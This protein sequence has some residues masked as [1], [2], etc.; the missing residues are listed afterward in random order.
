MKKLKA[1]FLMTLLVL[2]AVTAYFVFLGKNVYVR[3]SNNSMNRKNVFLKAWVDDKIIF[4]DS[5]E[6]DLTGR[7]RK[8]CAVKMARGKSYSIK[9]QV[10]DYPITEERIMLNW[11]AFVYVTV[12]ESS[13]GNIDEAI[14][15]SYTLKE[16]WD[17]NLL[18]G[19]KE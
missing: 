16:A 5:I 6:T 12:S 18:T 10:N 9:V 7:K 14:I 19:Q 17:M 11:F 1:V 15:N 13:A 3:L 8:T 4:N 2:L